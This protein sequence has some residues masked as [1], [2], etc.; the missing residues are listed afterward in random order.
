MDEHGKSIVDLVKHLFVETGK[1]NERIGF[2]NK[3]PVTGEWRP[4]GNYGEAYWPKIMKDS[5]REI[6]E[7]PDKHPAEYEKLLLKIMKRNG[8]LSVADAKKFLNQ[9]GVLQTNN[10]NIMGSLQF[11][12]KSFLPDSFYEYSFEKVIPTFIARWAD[13]ASKVESFGQDLQGGPDTNIFNNIKT[14]DKT[15]QR[16]IKAAKD[17]IYG[18]ESSLPRDVMRKFRTIA[19][20]TQLT[21]VINALKNMSTVIN[22]T[23]KFGPVHTT[24][25]L[26]KTLWNLKRDIREAKRAGVLMHDLISSNAD[27]MDMTMREQKF[28]QAALKATLFTPTEY[29]VRTHAAASALSWSRWAIREMAKNPD[30]RASLLNKAKAEELGISLQILREQGFDGEMANKLKRAA[31]NNTQFSYDLRSLPGWATTP[32]AKFFFQYY[33]FGIQA[34]N[35]MTHDV[36]RPALKGHIVENSK[37]QAVRVYDLKPLMIMAAG[38]LGLSEAMQALI[39]GATGKGRKDAT[40]SEIVGTAQDDEIGNAIKYLGMRL[41]HDVTFIGTV[42]LFGNQ[43]TSIEENSQK[44]K[45]L[46]SIKPPG[47][48]SI[49]NAWENLYQP[50]REQGQLTGHDALT[51]LRRA[52]PLFRNIDNIQK[53]IR[54]EPTHAALRDLARIRTL[55]YRY[56]DEAGLKQDSAIQKYSKNANT[57]AYREIKQALMIGDIDEATRLRDK[58]LDAAPK[59]GRGNVLIG[60]KSSINSGRPFSVGAVDSLNEMSA[61]K[62]WMLRRVGEEEFAHLLEMDKAYQLTASKLFLLNE[63]HIGSVQGYKNYNVNRKIRADNNVGGTDVNSAIVGE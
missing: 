52:L 41:L 61:F 8:Y 51:F 53:T 23:A 59:G 48:D 29:F 19:T 2:M 15:T 37:G 12:R 46:D 11:A 27:V 16:L 5:I 58:L 56:Q 14:S 24:V 21:G 22:T 43:A 30:S 55:G 6:L 54:G 34:A 36:I 47:T 26:A 7:N 17:A 49:F 25:G 39:N 40:F 9:N 50:F 60:L 13:E 57:P 44:S 62:A 42:G 18:H 28:T 4:I 1:V 20:V 3:D 38:T 31:S 32:E 45:P 10:M 33:N 63:T 35:F